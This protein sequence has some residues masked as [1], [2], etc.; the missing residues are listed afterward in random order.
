MQVKCQSYY[1]RTKQHIKVGMINE[2]MKE[3]EPTLFRI[4]LAAL[5]VNPSLSAPQ[6]YTFKLCSVKVGS[7][8]N[9]I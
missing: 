1:Y 5:H 7:I 2:Q 3:T 8:I 9:K 6:R 4:N